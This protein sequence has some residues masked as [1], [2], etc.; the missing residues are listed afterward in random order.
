MFIS[1]VDTDGVEFTINTDYIV[2]V[3]PVRYQESTRLNL[4]PDHYARIVD[5]KYN[6]FLDMLRGYTT[7]A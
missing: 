6:V 1:L 5:M 3:E 7:P 4:G 2:S